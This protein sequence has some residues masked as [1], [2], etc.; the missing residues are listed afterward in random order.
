MSEINFSLKVTNKQGVTIE[1]IDIANLVGDIDV[2]ASKINNKIV[3]GSYTRGIL[4]G[5]SAIETGSK[6]SF[7]LPIFQTATQDVQDIVEYWKTYL[8]N[9]RIYRFFLVRTQ[10]NVEYHR[11][12]VPVDNLGYKSD[13]INNAGKSKLNF[14]FIDN[15]YIGENVSQ[16][17]D[18]FSNK[19]VGSFETNF[20]SETKIE[21][22]SKFK[23]EIGNS[24]SFY[25]VFSFYAV[26]GTG[27]NFNSIVP[28][29]C[30][31]EFDGVNLLISGTGFSQKTSYFSGSPPDLTV[32]G[33]DLVFST[34]SNVESFEIIYNPRTDF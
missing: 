17:I 28:P 26:G 18:D 3:N 7:T 31:L 34:N 27:I 24:N 9:S 10:N 23:I 30:I 5:I 2:K 12:M 19:G 14:Q 32:D 4:Q 6:V 22:I 21:T 11:E 20:V 29:Q 25:Y 1:N 16:V 15:F 33:T 13:F 8:N